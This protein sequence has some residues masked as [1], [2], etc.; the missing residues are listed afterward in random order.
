MSVRIAWL[1]NT[2][3]D[4]V[5]Y[6]V[7]R[8]DNPGGTWS[9]LAVV[10]HNLTGPAYDPDVNQFFYIDAAGTVTQF[11]Q[12]TATDAQ[13]T[14]SAPSATGVPSSPVPVITNVAHVDHDYGGIDALRYAA[15]N[16]TPIN[17]AVIRIYRKI[18]FDQG[19]IQHPLAITRTDER[20][21]WVDPIYLTPG[22]TYVVQFAKETVCGPDHVEIIV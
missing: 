8:A 9:V 3:G 2:D 17:N 5:S 11:Y 18:D 12:V 1:P 21:E 13:G 14:V 16:G 15:I 10:P 6:S 22:Y 4:V 20:G 7:E 19:L